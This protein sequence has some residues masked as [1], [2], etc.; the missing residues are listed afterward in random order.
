VKKH[1]YRGITNISKMQFE[2]KYPYLRVQKIPKK[3]EYFIR[4]RGVEDV[5]GINVESGV[6]QFFE[7]YYTEE[8]MYDV[9]QL[10]KYLYRYMIN[11]KEGIYDKR[12]VSEEVS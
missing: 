7:E 9:R 10:Y 8:F 4:R 5:I 1:Y 6:F 3:Y 12:R 2:I 11:K